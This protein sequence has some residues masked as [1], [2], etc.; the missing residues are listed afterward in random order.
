MNPPATHSLVILIDDNE[1]DNFVNQKLIET[2]NFAAQILNFQS[3]E[4]AL[5]Y[6]KQN[7]ANPAAIP[8]VIFLDINMPVMDGFQFL[9]KFATLDAAITGKTRVIMLSTSDTFE[10]LN[11]ANQNKFVRKFLN[12]P[13]TNATLRALNLT[14]VSS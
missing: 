7:A 2:E 8:D 6:L 14:A 4:Q 12:K 13:L 3:A 10:D 5:D 11:R 9:D 1:L